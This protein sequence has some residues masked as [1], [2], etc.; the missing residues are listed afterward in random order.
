[1]DKNSIQ[2]FISYCHA[3]KHL[4]EKLIT[5]LRSLRFEYNINEIWHDGEI[6]AGH[7]IDQEVLEQLNKSDVILLLVSSTFL[8][9]YYCI[10]IELKEAIKRME[11]GECLVI[12]II[13]SSCTISDN[14]S[15]S[16]LRRLPTDGHP[17]SSRKYF[18]TQN[19]GCTNVT[20]DLK[21]NLKKDFPNAVIHKPKTKRT[22]GKSKPDV[23][24]SSCKSSNKVYIE[25]Y[26]DGRKQPV[27]VSQDLIFQIPRYHAAIHN[28]R[29][30]MEQSLSTSKQLYAKNYKESIN[31]NLPM[32]NTTRLKLLRIFLMDI[33]S[34]TKT[35]I[36]DNIGIKVHFRV[37]KDDKYIGLI[38][39]TDNEDSIDL[40]SDWATL[41]T[42]L[43]VYESLIY[44][45]YRFNAPLLNS[46]NMDLSFKGKGNSVWKDYVAFTFNGLDI[47]NTPSISYCISV[48]KNYYKTRGD[49]LL[50][51]AYLNFGDTVEKCIKDYCNLCKKI[52]K[53][54]DLSEIIKSV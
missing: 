18:Q 10:D 52:D 44:N 42:P 50:I 22:T 2:F 23:Q 49:V 36:T 9:S 43:P 25:L 38:A 51:L 39:S 48:H 29:T 15:F 12:P 46:L 24:N 7:N 20:D 14:L 35:F 40:A 31:K 16:R 41:L 4:K 11:R 17:I 54:Y 45:S 3:D 32:G 47:G 30:M 19:D 33:C 37:S 26:K 8:S 53:N 34:F 1:M 5:S 27:E 28:F 6:S 21:V 13:L